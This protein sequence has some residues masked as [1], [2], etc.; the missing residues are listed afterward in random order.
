MARKRRSLITGRW[1]KTI[2]GVRMGDYMVGKNPFDKFSPEDRMEW[3]KK[4]VSAEVNARR[5]AKAKENYLKDPEKHSERAFKMYEDHPEL[6][7]VRSKGM[8]RHRT[9]MENVWT[10]PEMAKIQGERVATF[11]DGEQVIIYV[12]TPREKTVGVVHE[13]YGEYESY[14]ECEEEL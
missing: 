1:Y 13:A 14:E 5:S 9:V 8:R 3:I 12:D 4:S 2:R 11:K 10:D 7:K 6:R